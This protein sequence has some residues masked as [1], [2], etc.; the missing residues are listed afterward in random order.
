MQKTNGT[1]ALPVLETPDGQIVKESLVILDFLD[2]T[3]AGARLRRSDPLEHAIERML[4]ATEAQFTMAG[5]LF[6]MNQDV[7]ARDTHRNKLLGIYRDINDFLI[8]QASS[9]PFLFEDFGLA[10]IV[11]TPLF[12]RFWFLDYFEGFSLPDNS[13]YAR[14]AAWRS[15]CMAHTATQQVSKEEIVKLYYDYALGY[16]N[17]ALP[18]GRTISSFSFNPPWQQRP[19]PPSEKYEAPATD[20]ELGLC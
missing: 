4:I 2:E 18:T 9:E 19:W 15:A 13:D 1:T 17:G 8:R 5:Y 6:V 11:F 7:S 12:K 16:G 20:T 14:V 10:E 3:I